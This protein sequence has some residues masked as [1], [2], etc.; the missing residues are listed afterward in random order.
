VVGGNTQRSREAEG[1]RGRGRKGKTGGSRRSK[2]KRKMRERSAEGNM[3]AEG[4]PSFRSRPIEG[5]LG[6][7]AAFG[8]VSSTGAEEWLDQA[9]D[10]LEVGQLLA[11]EE[12]FE[13]AA[14]LLQQAVEKALKAGLVDRGEDLVR[15]HDCFV[16]A[17]TLEA[18]QG[19]LDA[20]DTVTPYYVRSRYPDATDLELTAEDVDPLVAAAEE[21]I[22]WTRKTLSNGSK[23]N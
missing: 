14:F 21:V 12:R 22:T 4:S 20:A 13:H 5:F 10:D 17:E 11:R 9:Q 1:S 23:R 2:G 3:M 18:P 6:G 15:T 8:P 19:I 16:L 7:P